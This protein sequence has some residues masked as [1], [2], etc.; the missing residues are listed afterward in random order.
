MGEVGAVR[1]VG[2]TVPATEEGGRGES[3]LVLEEA[4][5]NPP[6]INWMMD[7]FAVTPVDYSEGRSRSYGRWIVGPEVLVTKAK[8]GMKMGDKLRATSMDEEGDFLREK[9]RSS[10]Q[11]CKE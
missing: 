10:G 6:E 7:Y 1:Y 2:S 9:Q 4:G 3:E 5:V 11:R 8:T